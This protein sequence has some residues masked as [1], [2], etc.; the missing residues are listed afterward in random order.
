MDIGGAA[1]LGGLLRRL[2]W[3]PLALASARVPFFLRQVL[4]DLLKKYPA[5][6][7][8]GFVFFEGV[9]IWVQVDFVFRCRQIFRHSAGG[10]RA[11]LDLFLCR[12]YI[13]FTELTIEVKIDHNLPNF[14]GFLLIGCIKATGVTM[15]PSSGIVIPSRALM[16]QRSISALMIVPFVMAIPSPLR[17]LRV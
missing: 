6:F 8:I 9:G 12:C 10:L 15:S 7:E 4:V 14:H 16:F 3:E 2:G 1:H 11:L 17:G 5:F 13:E